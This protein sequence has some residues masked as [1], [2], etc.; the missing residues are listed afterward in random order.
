MEKI[1]GK[2][3]S[4]FE[5]SLDAD[6]MNDMNIIEAIA[7]TMEDNPLALAKLCK[8]L[9]GEEQKKALYKHLQNERGK[10]P[11]EKVGEA[12]VEVFNSFGE[13]GKN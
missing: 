13:E 8:M 9:F 3:Q 4:G 12:V 1:K 10:V 5:Y 6:V 11:V 2:L 7:D